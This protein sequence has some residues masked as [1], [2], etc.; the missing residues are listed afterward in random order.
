MFFFFF[1]Y[2]SNTFDLRYERVMFGNALFHRRVRKGY[3]SQK[4]S[5]TTII[6]RK[7]YRERQMPVRN[8]IAVGCT[9]DRRKNKD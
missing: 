4:F 7:Q 9:P 1:F 6:T 3:K 2:N 8:C 5:G